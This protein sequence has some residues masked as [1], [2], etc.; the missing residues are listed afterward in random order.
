MTV[1]PT[2]L[3]EQFVGPFHENEK[4]DLIETLLSTVAQ[5]KQRWHDDLATLEH[6]IPK[7]EGGGNTLKNLMLACSACNAEKGAEYLKER[8]RLM[9]NNSL[10]PETA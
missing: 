7:A 4:G 6:I 3:I 2:V 8:E 1:L 9:N 5:F 10:I